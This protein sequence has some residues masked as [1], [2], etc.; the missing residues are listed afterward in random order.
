MLHWGLKKNKK[1]GNITTVL[2]L[3]ILANPVSSSQKI[4]SGHTRKNKSLKEKNE[5]YVEFCHQYLNW[6]V[7]PK[8]QH[9]D[10]AS[11]LYGTA[12]TS[13]DKIVY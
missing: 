9:P 2:E 11:Y 7:S 8:E 12:I 3:F 13:D 1:T 10:S 5:L 6:L 4:F